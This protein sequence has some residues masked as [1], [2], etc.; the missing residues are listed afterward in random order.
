MT[1]ERFRMARTNYNKIM[2][3]YQIPSSNMNIL[4]IEYTL[5]DLLLEQIRNVQERLSVN[6]LGNSE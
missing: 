3:L 4:I 6:I 5:L 1:R 2:R